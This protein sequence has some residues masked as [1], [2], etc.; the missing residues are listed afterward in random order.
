MDQVKQPQVKD[1]PKSKKDWKLC[2]NCFRFIGL[3][4]PI[5]PHCYEKQDWA[6]GKFYIEGDVLIDRSV[7]FKTMDEYKQ[8]GR[9]LEE[10]RRDR[11]DNYV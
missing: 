9:T 11:K 1:Q 2:D 3:D 6:K 8:H 10:I 4:K 5:C 7:K